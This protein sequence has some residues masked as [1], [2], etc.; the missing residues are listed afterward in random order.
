[1]IISCSPAGLLLDSLFDSDTLCSFSMLH[2]DCFDREA[3]GFQ[4][5]KQ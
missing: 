2:T 1:M 3:L 4:P 5:R